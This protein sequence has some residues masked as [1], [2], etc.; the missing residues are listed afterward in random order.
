MSRLFFREPDEPIT[1]PFIMYTLPSVLTMKSWRRMDECRILD[2]AISRVAIECRRFSGNR[3]LGTRS[4]P[5]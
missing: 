1:V 4:T 3:F 2:E 5:P